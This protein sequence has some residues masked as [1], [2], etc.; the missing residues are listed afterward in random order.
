[1][2]PPFSNSIG[3]KQTKRQGKAPIGSASVPL[4]P[5]RRW[6][7]DAVHSPE[8]PPGGFQFGIQMRHRLLFRLFQ[9]YE[10][11]SLIQGR[12][13]AASERS[14]DSWFP[15]FGARPPGRGVHR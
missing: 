14:P 6:E 13:W 3:L 15:A 5:Y 11:F 10:I 4:L 1:M 9:M 7:S 2:R 12:G 8:A